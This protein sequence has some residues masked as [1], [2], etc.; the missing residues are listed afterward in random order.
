ML[1]TM[2][3]VDTKRIT[4]VRNR[5]HKI[6]ESVSRQ[7]AEEV[8]DLCRQVLEILYSVSAGR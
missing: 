1:A 3:D 4:E 5:V 7:D 6:Y 8:E 2:R